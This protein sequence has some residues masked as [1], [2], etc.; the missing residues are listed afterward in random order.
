MSIS[1]EFKNAFLI[2]LVDYSKFQFSL[3]CEFASLFWWGSMEL[4]KL[5]KYGEWRTVLDPRSK[6]LFSE[7]DKSEQYIR[8][9]F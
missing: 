1:H 5:R 6:I 2:Y 3:F 4:G 8:N 9:S 7:L